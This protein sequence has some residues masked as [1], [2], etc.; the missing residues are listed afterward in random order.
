MTRAFILCSLF[1]AVELAS[2][3]LNVCFALFVFIFIDQNESYGVRE[4]KYVKNSRVMPD[5]QTF[6]R[7]NTSKLSEVEK[8]NKYQSC[9][10][11]L[12]RVNFSFRCGGVFPSALEC[13]QLNLI[14]N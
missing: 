12:A 4:T 10:L 6:V 13:E 5:Q 1:S 9:L 11:S 8:M 3:T 2:D 14:N 7:K